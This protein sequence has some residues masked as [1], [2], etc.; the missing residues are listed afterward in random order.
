MQQHACVNGQNSIACERLHAEETNAHDETLME[1]ARRQPMDP[2]EDISGQEMFGRP[3]SAEGKFC[4]RES[5]TH[6][7]N[8]RTAIMI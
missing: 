6:P 2:H 4:C 8:D 3:A 7:E 5:H 1:A